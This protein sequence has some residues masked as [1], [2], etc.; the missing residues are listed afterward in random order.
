VHAASSCEAVFFYFASFPDL[1]SVSAHGDM[2]VKI[3]L[4][5]EP[6]DERTERSL[7][8]FI[9]RYVR[10][11]FTFEY[12]TSTYSLHIADILKFFTFA[13][14]FASMAHFIQ[15][16]PELEIFKNNLWFCIC[17][18]M[19]MH[20]IEYCLYILSISEAFLIL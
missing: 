4:V 11:L 17:F 16:V 9:E 2:E 13:L 14:S 12:R 20:S 8:R 19:K 3:S 7:N 1:S 10:N 18:V 6:E 15:R 5:T